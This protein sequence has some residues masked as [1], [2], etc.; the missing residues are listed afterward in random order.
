MK[1]LTHTDKNGRARQVD[2]GGKPVQKRIATATG[3]INMKPETL[4]LV[5]ENL[6]KKGDVFTV[7][8]IAG[9]Q[10]A[11]KCSELIPLCH[12]LILDQVSVTLAEDEGG[13]E[14][15]AAA[16]CTGRT[17]VE[18]EALTSVSVALLT[19]YDMCKAVDKEMTL[20]DIKLINK[21]K[22]DIA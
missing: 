18:M 5:R 10:A 15:T 11:K 16:R 1:G 19:V 13:I 2:T 3:R 21:E 8:E 14:V 17:G 9:I 20:T 12:N 4:R 22:H 7:A 6:L